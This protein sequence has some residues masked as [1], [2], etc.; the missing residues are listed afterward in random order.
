MPVEKPSLVRTR[1]RVSADDRNA[2]TRIRHMCELQKSPHYVRTSMR[3]M[4]FH[5]GRA[6]GEPRIKRTSDSTVGGEFYRDGIP[7]FSHAEA[8]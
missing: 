6:L 5:H 1:V 7:N 3:V 2:R 8:N 4:S